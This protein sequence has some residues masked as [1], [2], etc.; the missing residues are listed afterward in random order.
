MT[1]FRPRAKISL[2]TPRTL[3]LI[4]D[5]LRKQI[6][7]PPKSKDERQ[8]K[9]R[10]LELD[11]AVGVYHHAYFHVGLPQD[12]NSQGMLA[13]GLRADNEKIGLRGGKPLEG[14]FEERVD[15]MGL[16]LGAIAFHMLGKG[17]EGIGLKTLKRELGLR[18]E[19]MKHGTVADFAED[20]DLLYRMNNH[21]LEFSLF[22]SDISTGE[23]SWDNRTVRRLFCRLLGDSLRAG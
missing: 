5:I 19:Q 11:T 13:Q 3:G 14:N 17:V 10:E 20:L 15:R 8:K 16:V 22:D 7:R 21:T 18:L 1:I 4:C 12:P 2:A 23:L 6:P 9:I